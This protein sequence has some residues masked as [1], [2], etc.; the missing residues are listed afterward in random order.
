MLTT[1]MAGERK[2][3]KRAKV[4]GTSTPKKTTVPEVP[5]IG[6]GSTWKEDQ[7]DLYKVSVR[8]ADVKQMI[9]E[10]WFDFGDLENFQNG[11]P[12]YPQTDV[13]PGMN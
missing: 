3:Q 2:Q 1:A 8:D 11:F 13:E 9:P 4:T 5:V 6:S 10:K 12:C 7:L